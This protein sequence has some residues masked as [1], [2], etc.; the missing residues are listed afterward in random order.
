MS[1]TCLVLRPVPKSVHEMF[2]QSFCEA[3]GL[4]N[5]SGQER[6]QMIEEI[7]SQKL[8][9]NMHPGT[10]FLPVVDDDV[11][12]DIPT[13]NSVEAWSSGGGSTIPGL[14]WCKELLVGDSQM[15][16]SAHT[17]LHQCQN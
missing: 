17:L 7:D 10:P 9:L 2:Y 16:V 1:G 5:V 11:I 3:Q 13:F 15:D 12:N 4:T 6:I 8:L 14:Q